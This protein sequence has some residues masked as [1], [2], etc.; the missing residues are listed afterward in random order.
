MKPIKHL[1]SFFYFPE[2]NNVKTSPNDF[3]IK[4]NIVG[5]DLYTML[6]NC[7]PLLCTSYIRNIFSEHGSSDN[8][9]I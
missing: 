1:R 9:K 8:F 3:L 2:K 4:Q 5:D 6:R 7:F